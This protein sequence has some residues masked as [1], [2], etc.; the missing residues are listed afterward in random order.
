MLMLLLRRKHG[1]HVRLFLEVGTCPCETHLL[2]RATVDRGQK[3]LV[4]HRLGLRLKLLKL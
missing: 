2:I 3:L 4:C 1:V